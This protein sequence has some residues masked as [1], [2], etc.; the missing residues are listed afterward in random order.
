MIS[1]YK[2]V[3]DI[4]LE[5]STFV[6]VKILC[7]AMIVFALFPFAAL[8]SHTNFQY[9]KPSL[10]DNLVLFATAKKNRHSLIGP[11]KSRSL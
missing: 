8:I 10:R 3:Q 11:F 7:W 5:Q 4:I 9:N 6:G 2:S 1:E